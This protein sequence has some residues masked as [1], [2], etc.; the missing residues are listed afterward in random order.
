MFESRRFI[1]LVAFI[2][3]IWITIDALVGPHRLPDRIPVHF[4]SAGNPNGWGSPASLMLPLFPAIALGVFVLMSFIARHP[5]LFNYPVQVTDENRGRLQAITLN[6]LA[7]MRMEM[8]CLFATVQWL[9]ISSARHPQ[10]GF[11]QW[12]GAP[13]VAWIVVIFATVILNVLALRRAAIAR[14]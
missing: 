2:Y 6:L 9:I 3:Q 13:I 4:D 10:G 14:G 7:W 5:E 8:V 12:V 1:A 11:S